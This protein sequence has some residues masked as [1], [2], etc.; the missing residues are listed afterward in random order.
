MQ[1][2]M[3]C[4]P[5]LPGQYLCVISLYDLWGFRTLELLLTTDWYKKM[6]RKDL[7]YLFCLKVRKK[8]TKRLKTSQLLMVLV[9]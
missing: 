4:I 2:T 3:K 5:L 6:S 8:D 7:L 9:T 1:L